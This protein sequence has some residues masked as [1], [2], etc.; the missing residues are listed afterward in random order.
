MLNDNSSYYDK[1][2]YKQVSD[3]KKDIHTLIYINDEAKRFTKGLEAKRKEHCPEIQAIKKKETHKGDNLVKEDLETFIDYYK[4]CALKYWDWADFNFKETN[5]YSNLN[6]FTDEIDKQG[7]KITF[8]NISKSYIDKMVEEQKLYLFEIYSKDFSTK[9]KKVGTDNLHTIYWKALFEKK[10]LDDVVIKLNGQA[11]LFYRK[12][13]LNYSEEKRK[14]GHHYDD[15][16]DKFQYPIIKDKRYSEDKILFHCPVTLNFKAEGKEYINQFNQ[17]I[18][19]FL[20]DN[21]KKIN[22]IG[23]DRG[24]KNLLYYSVISQQGEIL[25]QGSFNKID[26]E[27]T[28]AGSDEPQKIDYHQKLD[29][30]EKERAKARENWETIENIKELKSGYLSQVVHQLSKLIIKHNA[31]VVLENLNAGFKRGRFKFEKQIYQKFETAL[32]HKLNYLVDKKEDDFNKTGHYLKAYQL[33]N[34]FKTFNEIG[35]QSGILFYTAAGYTS[36][37]D[38][39]TGYMRNLYHSYNKDKVEKTQEFFKKFESIIYNGSHFEFTYNLK[40]LKGMTGTYEDKNELDESK[41]NKEWTIHSHVYRTQYKEIKLT[42]EERN[43]EEYKE[44]ING[45]WRRNVHVDVNQKLKDLFKQE[46]IQ[47]E[48]DKCYKEM[49]CDARKKEEFEQSKF[50]AKLIAY[51]NRLLDMR[52]FTGDKDNKD[53]FIL[54]PVEPFFDSRKLKDI[55]KP[56]L[57]K[58]S[59]ANGAHNIARKGIMILDRIKNTKDDKFKKVGSITK[60]DWQNFCQKEEIVE[61]QKGKWEKIKNQLKEGRK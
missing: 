2:N 24:E 1:M 57:P 56:P 8:S 18:N 14:R 28:P 26:N 9:K 47:L 60:T 50:L 13:S 12:A 33:T 43:Q 38:P 51:F 40:K 61:K 36:K 45:K 30:K 55:E 25:E 32:I 7:Y 52:V 22:I 44:A 59:D 21:H 20:K 19:Q 29:A 23:I 6:D 16:K 53:D 17:D 11:E 54:S 27:F 58:D 31:I 41:I 39:I 4:K 48:K 49:I 5:E 3:A 42:E 34:K 46:N 10:N 15:L 37:T 35:N